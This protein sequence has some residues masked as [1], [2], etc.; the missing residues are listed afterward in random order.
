M[1]FDRDQL[2]VQT[3]V[4]IPDMFRTFLL[5]SGF[6]EWKITNTVTHHMY[7]RCILKITLECIH[8]LQI[9]QLSATNIC[10]SKYFYIYDFILGCY[11]DRSLC[12]AEYGFMGCAI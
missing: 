2:C 10:V 1:Q 3:D 5:L 9:L 6:H 12:D 11:T 7:L 4:L 8:I